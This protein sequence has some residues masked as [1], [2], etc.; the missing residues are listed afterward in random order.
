MLPVVLLVL[1]ALLMGGCGGDSKPAGGNPKAATV[2]HESEGTSESDRE[3]QERKNAKNKLS[4]A[5]GVA[6]YQIATTSG[7]LRARAV[8]LLSG[9]SGTPK[10]T[11]LEGRKRLNLLHPNSDALRLLRNLLANAIDNFEA[12]ETRASARAAMKDSE[13]I[14]ADLA[15]FSKG[16]AVHL[17]VPD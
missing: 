2:E 12:R 11:L 9:S 5:D 17:L 4:Q 1:A 3:E 8:T 6:Y 10:A 13:A 7:L 14:S 15:R 16:K